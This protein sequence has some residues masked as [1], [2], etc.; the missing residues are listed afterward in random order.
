MATNINYPI[1]LPCPRL[2]GNTNIPGNTFIRSQFDYGIRQRK[3]YCSQYGVGFTFIAKSQIQ[4]KAFKDFYYIT[5]NN[6]VDSFLADWQIQGIDGTKEFRF[7]DVY[8]VT[9]LG[10]NKFSISASFDMIT[11]I[12]DL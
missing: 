4:M 8:D 3:Q 12:K 2:S 1:D 6:G 5:L 11:K 7:S 10:S 9:A